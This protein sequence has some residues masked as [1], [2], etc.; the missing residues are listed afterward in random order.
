MN[1]FKASNKLLRV[2]IEYFQAFV[3]RHAGD[4]DS[5]WREREMTD[6]L[7]VRILKRV[8]QLFFLDIHHFYRPIIRSSDQVFAVRR[9]CDFVD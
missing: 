8:N 2:T 7:V 5:A 9:T 3:F 4:V 1:V 6:R